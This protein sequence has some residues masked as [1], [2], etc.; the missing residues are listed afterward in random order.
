MMIHR[1]IIDSDEASLNSFRFDAISVVMALQSIIPNLFRIF[2]A[3]FPYPRKIPSAFCHTSKNSS[4]THN[5]SIT[6]LSPSTLKQ[7][8]ESTL[9]LVKP[10]IIS[11]LSI[12]S[13]HVEPQD[14][15]QS[16]PLTFILYALK[17]SIL[18]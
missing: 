14:L 2:T 8:L 5:K 12:M 10:R 17:H 7:R 18:E 16:L 9:L 1:S 6:G 3:Y 13:Y 4:S 11:K 15:L